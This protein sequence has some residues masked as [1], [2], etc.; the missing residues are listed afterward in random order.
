MCAHKK[1]RA[2]AVMMDGTIIGSRNSRN[3]APVAR[4]FE[5]AIPSAAS[6]VIAVVTR[7]VTSPMPNERTVAP[8][9]SGDSK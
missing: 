3:S 9:H 1:N 4:P 6:V 7:A 2:I 8:I 5:R